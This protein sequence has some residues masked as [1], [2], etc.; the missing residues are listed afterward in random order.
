MFWGFIFLLIG[1]GWILKDLGYLPANMDIFWPILFI[2]LG[3]AI[4]FGR[5]R[6]NYWVFWEKDK[7]K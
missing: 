4:I 6:K 3:L 5:R 2:A 1:A 7:D